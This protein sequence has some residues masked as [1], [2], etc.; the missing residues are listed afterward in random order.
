MRGRRNELSDV[1]KRVAVGA[2]DAC[3]EWTGYRLPSGYGQMALGGVA[4]NA[5][6]VAFEDA[7]G[8]TPG[9]LYVC[10]SCDNPPCCN[11]AHLFLGTPTENRRDCAEKRRDSR[12]ER[13]HAAKLTEREVREIRRLVDI[14]SSALARRFGVSRRL[15]RMVR[16]REVWRHV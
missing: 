8:I 13:H 12:G 2:P 16:N 1:W 11:P 6:R 9:G 15:V 4:I 10:H 7:A 5:H 14:S 3:W